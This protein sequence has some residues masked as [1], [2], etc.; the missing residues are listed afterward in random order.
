M[1]GFGLLAR[2][3]DAAVRKRRKERWNKMDRAERGH[4]DRNTWCPGTLVLL[5]PSADYVAGV[6]FCRD[7]SNIHVRCIYQLYVAKDI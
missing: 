5:P 6:D 1:Y 4:T 2:P 3:G 7:K